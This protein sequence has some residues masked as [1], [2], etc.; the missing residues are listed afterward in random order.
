MAVLPFL[1]F[2]S[3]VRKIFFL[4]TGL[5]IILLSYFMYIQIKAITEMDEKGGGIF[6]DEDDSDMEIE[7]ESIEKAPNSDENQVLDEAISED[8]E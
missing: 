4:M 6:V 2:P 1:G 7:S 8:H 3:N 5:G